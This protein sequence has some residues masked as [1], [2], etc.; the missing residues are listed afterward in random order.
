MGSICLVGAAGTV[1]KG[2]ETSRSLGKSI[3]NP[4][5]GSGTAAINEMVPCF[6]TLNRIGN[7]KPK[8]KQIKRKTVCTGEARRD[9]EGVTR[10]LEKALLMLDGGIKALLR[11]W[12][13][14]STG[15]V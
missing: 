13:V 10:D 4:L 6:L 12:R 8:L 11:R 2:L 9:D 7:R 1:G 15:K 14:S 3:W 5:L